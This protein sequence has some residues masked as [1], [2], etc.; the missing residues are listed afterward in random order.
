[1]DNENC[2]MNITIEDTDSIIQRFESKQTILQKIYS[3]FFKK[4]KRITPL[5]TSLMVSE[6]K[7]NN[8]ELIRLFYHSIR[9]PINNSLLGI[10]ILKDIIEYNNNYNSTERELLKNI[11][12]SIL[13]ANETLEKYSGIKFLLDTSK[14]LKKYPFNLVGFF[15]QLEFLLYFTFLEK[16][17][18]YVWEIQN[19]ICNW[20]IGDEHNL[21]HVF[22][23]ILKNS[24]F[25]SVPYSI[26]YVNISAEL[27]NVKEQLVRIV[28]TDSNM[29]KKKNIK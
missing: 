19:E 15:E 27:I 7:K 1:M 26:I 11:H 17:V 10:S 29:K 9:G 2:L 14:N 23:N 16:K 12:Y 20:V 22:I 13:F 24:A 18:K 5:N 8:N 3:F 21:M 4:K 28:I 6:K 25:N